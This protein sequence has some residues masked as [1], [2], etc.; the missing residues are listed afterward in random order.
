MTGEARM[1]R[2]PEFQEILSLLPGTVL[3]RGMEQFTKSEYRSSLAAYTDENRGIFERMQRFCARYPQ[4]TDEALRLACR[5][6]LDAVA[7]DLDAP[8]KKQGLNERALRLDA[9]KMVIVTYL[10][11]AVLEMGLEIGEP[12]VR[13]LREEWLSRCPRQSY[14]LVTGEMIAQGFE[15]KWYQCYITQ[16]VCT[17]L[18][19]CDDCRELTAFRRFRDTYLSACPDGPALIDEYDRDAPKIVARI[20]LWGL[21]GSVYPQLWEQDLLPC[22][23][24]IEA[25]RPEECKMRYERMTRRL[26]RR[27]LH[28]S[29]KS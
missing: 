1:D 12:F 11:P 22:L 2:D 17:Y 19:R 4:R 26:Q 15:K 28:R 8:R 23:R 16:A 25:G 13:A 18:G 6:L 20:E 24:A 14:E 27:F 29:G 5:T 3:G 10:T 7:A 9:C 21:S